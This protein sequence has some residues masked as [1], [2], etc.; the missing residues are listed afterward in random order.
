[1]ENLRLQST[2]GHIDCVAV[3]PFRCFQPVSSTNCSMQVALICFLTACSAAT[4]QLPCSPG[5]T[6]LSILCQSDGQDF[7]RLFVFDLSQLLFSCTDHGHEFE[8]VAIGG[9]GFRL[10]EIELEDYTS[11]GPTTVKGAG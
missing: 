3:Y 11:Q 10:L 1:M 6:N 2:C 5:S 7:S 9:N 8:D 4:S